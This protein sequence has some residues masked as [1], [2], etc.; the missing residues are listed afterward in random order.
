MRLSRTQG[1]SGVTYVSVPVVISPDPAIAVTPIVN[2]V[3]NA[4]SAT[5]KAGITRFVLNS[6]S[7][8]AEKTVYNNSHT[9]TKNTFNHAE[10]AKAVNEPT[11]PTIEPAL[12]VYSAGRT[13]AELAFWD[14][15]KE[16]KEKCPQLV[17]NSVVSDGNFGRVLEPTKTGTGPVTS[18]GML[19]RE[20]RGKREGVMP[21]VDK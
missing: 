2:T 19:Q 1:A 15:V 13:S 14:W 18:V 17:A 4:L 8:A 12:T 21:F 5:A 20:E 10:V 11:V 9:I 3:L 16:N 7:K 6:S